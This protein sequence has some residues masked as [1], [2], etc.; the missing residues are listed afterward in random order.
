MKKALISYPEFV[1]NF[2]GSEGYRVAQV[3]NEEDIFP[4]ADS[5]EWVSCSADATQD[6][7]YFDIKLKEVILKPSKPAVGTQPI[8]IGTQDF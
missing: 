6:A 7:W 4:V 3:E 2:D 8:S 1:F 5:L